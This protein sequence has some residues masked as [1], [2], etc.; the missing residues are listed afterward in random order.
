MQS[1]RRLS[2]NIGR[3]LKRRCDFASGG[4]AVDGHKP[5]ISPRHWEINMTS[6][7]ILYRNYFIH[8][9]HD[10]QRWRVVAI[11]H[12]L[13]GR[14]LLPPAFNYLERAEAE[15]YAKAAIDVQLSKSI[16]R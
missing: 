2:N 6:A 8:L 5:L 12:S 1:E 13:T 11:I 16:R 9:E 14:G 3:G 15:R 4:I 7:R 10:A